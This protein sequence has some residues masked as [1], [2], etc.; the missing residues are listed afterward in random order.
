MVVLGLLVGTV[1][2]FAA[3]AF[4]WVEHGLQHVVWSW[5]PETLGLSATPW[6]YVTAALLIGA[7]VVMVAWRVPGGGFGH[8]PVEGL[9]FDVVPRQIL[10]VLVAAL[11]SLVF[12]AVVGPEAPLIAVGT[13]TGALLVRRR[14]EQVVRLAMVVGGAA[15]IG[16]IFG[17]PLITA[18]MLL[19]FAAVG[20]MPAAV[21]LPSFVALGASYVVQVGIGDWNGV[22]TG[23]MQVSGLAK[24]ADITWP[25]LLASVVVGLLAA[26]LALLA[27]EGGERIVAVFRRR[28]AT[29]LVAGAIV[30]AAVAIL[31]QA[32]TGLDASIVLFSGQSAMPTLLAQTSVGAVIVILVTKAIAYAVGL[33]GGFRGGPIF[34][35]LFLGVGVGVLA[36][37]VSGQLTESGM[38]VAG[39]AAATTALLRLPL[40]GALFAVLIGAGAGALA[41]PLAII[42]SVVGLLARMV[43]DRYDSAH[44]VSPLPPETAPATT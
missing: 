1:A 13:A 39:M 27:R 16:A 40:S 43:L 11:G 18:F 17:N 6:W 30:T 8:A 20:L 35:A 29:T 19:E 9:H 23:A 34:P 2:A 32:L 14:P 10:S 3:S 44:H 42:G 38:V 41:T 26:V 7:G 22:G 21:L 28:P 36:A 37:L 33:G 24:L 4:I 5:L 25:D 15:A 12:G 31:A